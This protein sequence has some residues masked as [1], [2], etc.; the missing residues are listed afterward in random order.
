MQ[1]CL[2]NYLPVF[3][4]VWQLKSFWHDRTLTEDD[5]DIQTF[6][7]METCPAVSRDELR[8]DLP[9]KRH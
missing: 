5:V 6:E 7:D 2:R 1:A 8:G 3:L 4:H 9:A